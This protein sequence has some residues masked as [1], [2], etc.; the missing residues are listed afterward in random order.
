[1]N[2]GKRKNLVLLVCGT[3]VV[4]LDQLIKWQIVERFR[5]G[6]SLHIVPS[7]FS[8]TYI[9]N[10][11]AAFGLFAHADPAFRIPFFIIVPT[12]A[13]L[14]IAYAFKRIAATDIKLS[15]ALSLIVGGAIGNLID[16]V[17]LGYVVDFFLFHWRYQYYFPAF[18]IADAA[19]CVGV[20]ILM[21]DVFTSNE[22]S[23]NNSQRVERRE[24]SVDASTNR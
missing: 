15:F 5:L 2:L 7:Y 16:R 22:F 4:V 19:I 21:V 20:G 12:V 23:E 1:M 6:E 14:A 10:T 9:R 18:N 24:I 17:F 13:L 3:L 11:G 8:L